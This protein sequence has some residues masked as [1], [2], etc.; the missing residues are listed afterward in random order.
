MRSKACRSVV[1]L[2]AAPMSS[3]PRGSE[4]IGMTRG[5]SRARATSP[6]TQGC[7]VT[8]AAQRL[9]TVAAAG[10]GRGRRKAGSFAPNR[11]LPVSDRIAGSGV[12]AASI[13]VSTAT[14]LA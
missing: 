5:T 4:S 3:W 9:Q 11:W 7:P 14:A 13:A 1:A 12:M 10:F 6:Q 2:G 8:T